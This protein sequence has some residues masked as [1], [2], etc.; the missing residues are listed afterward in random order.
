ME[1]HVITM[2]EISDVLWAKGHVDF[3]EFLKAAREFTEN[4]I[5]HVYRDLRPPDAAH[6]TWL[7]KNPDPSGQYKCIVDDGTPGRQGTFPATVSYD[8]DD[9][10][11]PY[12]H[13]DRMPEEGE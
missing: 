5:Y 2:E 3:D 6:Y 1:I 7:R 13:W 11:S 10:F 8:P 9:A 4:D 12:K